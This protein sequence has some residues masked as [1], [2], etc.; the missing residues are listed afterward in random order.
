MS[1]IRSGDNYDPDQLSS[2][3]EKLRRYYLDRGF[4]DFQVVSS[5]A[6]LDRERNAF[7]IVFTINEG[8][9]YRFGDINVDS[10]ISGRR[11]GVTR[12][13]GLHR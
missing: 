6:E 3:E 9:R 10:T 1:F 4:A 12:A 2:D 7:F 5:V 11:P 13:P 8:P